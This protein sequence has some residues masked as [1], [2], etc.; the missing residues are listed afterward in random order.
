MRAARQRARP[1]GRRRQRHRSPR[2][3][4]P[5][6]LNALAATADDVVLVLDDFHFV[7]SPACHNQVQFLIDELPAQAHLVIVTRAD[8]GLRMGRLRASGRPGRDPRRRPRLHHGRGDRRCSPTTTCTCT[9]RPSGSW[10]NAPRAGPRGCTSPPCRWP[11]GPIPTTFVREFSD[12]NRFIGDYLTEEVLSRHSDGFGSSSRR[13]RSWTASRASLCDHVRG[14]T[15]SAAILHDLERS[16]LFLVPLDEEREVVPVPPPVRRR[17][18]QRA[19]LEDPTACP[20]CTRGPPLVP[21]PR[22]RRRGRH[23]LARLRRDDEAAQL[24]QANW[25][26]TSTPAAADRGRLARLAGPRRHRQWSRGAR[27]GCVDGRAV[28]Q[29]CGADRSSGCVGGVR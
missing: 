3:V 19:E 9:R 1:R 21:R 12:G 27:H 5:A 24:V 11:A 25:L 7:Q 13:S 6:S 16:N 18:A 26:S 8:P 2:A 22:P 10:W 15:D 29:P 17:G 23:A 28:R 20:A 14:T 4:L